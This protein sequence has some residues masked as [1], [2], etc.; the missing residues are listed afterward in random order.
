[1]YPR[2]E[3]A[4]DFNARK[5]PVASGNLGS[6]CAVGNLTCVSGSDRLNTGQSSVATGLQLADVQSL[7]YH[8]VSEAMDDPQILNSLQHLS[9]SS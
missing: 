8:T 7:S 4:R 9:A 5:R 6:R 1:V 2:S 3:N